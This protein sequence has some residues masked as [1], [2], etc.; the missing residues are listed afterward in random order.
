MVDE[1]D[2]DAPEWDELST[3][4]KLL[5]DK[6]PKPERYRGEKGNA[7]CELDKLEEFIQRRDATPA[8]RVRVGVQLWQLNKTILGVGPFCWRDRRRPRGAKG[9]AT[10]TEIDDQILKRA[11]NSKPLKGSLGAALRPLVEEVMD[12][13]SLRRLPVESHIKRLRTLAKRRGL[14]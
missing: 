6:N 14:A 11:I 8:E 1:D 3:L 2:V 5:R 13:G 4:A 9:K 7:L 12:K 10:Y